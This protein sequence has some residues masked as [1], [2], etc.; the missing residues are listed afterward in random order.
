MASQLFLLTSSGDLHLHSLQARENQFG[1]SEDSSY[2]V[3]RLQAVSFNSR[4]CRSNSPTASSGSQPSQLCIASRMHCTMTACSRLPRACR[5]QL[6]ALLVRL[7]ICVL[8]E[9]PSTCWRFTQLRFCPASSMMRIR[10]SRF[11]S[12]DAERRAFRTP[13]LFHIPVYC[14]HLHQ[15]HLNLKRLQ[16][17]STQ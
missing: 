17:R 15:R 1:Q 16:N 10:D 5:I 13:A 3:L 12:S 8:C 14:M 2:G 11:F 7:V 9:H 6:E 4:A